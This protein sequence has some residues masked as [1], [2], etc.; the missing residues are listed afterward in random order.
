MSVPK[1]SRWNRTDILVVQDRLGNITRKP[2]LMPIRPRRQVVF[3]DNRLYTPVRGDT[4]SNMA[5][6]FFG[7]SFLW[8]VI[9]EFN[10]IVDPV[11]ELEERITEGVALVIPSINRVNFDVLR[12]RVSPLIQ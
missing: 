6:R 4:W 8:W 3:G 2:Y 1:N 9:A 11:V 5:F 12:F 7:S 10:Y